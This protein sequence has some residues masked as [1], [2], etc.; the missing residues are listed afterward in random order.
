MTTC[1]YIAGPM[2]GYAEFNRPAFEEARAYLCGF[3]DRVISPWDKKVESNFPS[4]SEFAG[5]PYDES[6]RLMRAALAEDCRLIAEDSTHMHMLRGWEKSAGA[7][8]EWHLAKA[9]DLSISY[10]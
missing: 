9:L 4:T 1:C 7:V 2:R 8:V 10:E 3:H 5:L 6:N